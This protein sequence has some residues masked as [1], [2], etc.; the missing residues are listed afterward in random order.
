MHNAGLRGW[1]PNGLVQ[2][3]G[4][5]GVCNVA[6]LF[7]IVHAIRRCEA[8]HVISAIQLSVTAITLQHYIPI[9]TQIVSE[10]PFRAQ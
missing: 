7:R 3:N 6:E 10:H 4:L 8:G 9:E 5:H 1:T 2:I